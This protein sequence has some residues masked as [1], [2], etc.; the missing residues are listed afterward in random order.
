[1]QQHAAS[2]IAH[3]EGSTAAEL[4]RYIKD[5]FDAFLECGI[6]A[7]GFLRLHCGDCG[8]DK[9]V[10]FSC[11]RRGFC[12]SCGARRMAQT[13][14]LLVD[15]GHVNHAAQAVADWDE[16]QLSYRATGQR[17]DR[18]VASQQMVPG[19]ALQAG[20]RRWPG[21]QVLPAPGHDPHGVMLFNE[22]T[23][24]LL[25]ADALWGKGFGVVFPEVE[26]EPG[27]DDVEAVLDL[28]AGLP[29]KVVVPGHGAPFTDVAAALDRARSRLAA[30]RASPERHARYAFKVLVKYHLMEQGAMAESE[31]LPWARATPL[32]AGLL[33]SRGGVDAALRDGWARALVDELVIQ[34]A[35]AR[36]GGRLLDV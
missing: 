35:A 34:G 13:A 23:G 3:T 17:V 28:I 19:Q 6:L 15:T 36:Q 24:V 20:G 29:M 26:G 1:V 16:Q 12:P 5:E 2:F 27:F 33:Q 21:W 7:H 25:S 22:G 31:L 9:P 30:F 11:K 14:A 32:L 18:F 4:P 8:H 10:A